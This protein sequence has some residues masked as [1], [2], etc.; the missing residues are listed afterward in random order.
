MQG[1]MK[2]YGLGGPEFEISDY[3]FTIVF[4]RPVGVAQKT[5]QITP[6]ITPPKGLTELEGKIVVEI[7][8]NPMVSRREIAE[9]LGISG[10]TVKE[11][12]EKLK[13]KGVLKRV[14]PPRG[15]HWEVIE[16]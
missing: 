8:G 11:Y 4:K 12:L 10:D 1:A 13:E 2:D 9:R 3:W 15:G 16:K 7:M 6:Q 14:G 5:P